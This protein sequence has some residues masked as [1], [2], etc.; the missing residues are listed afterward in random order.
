MEPFVVE[1]T[2]IGLPAVTLQPASHTSDKATHDADLIQCSDGIFGDLYY[3]E[4]S[5]DC[6]HGQCL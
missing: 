5:Q 1:A 6:S 3:L 4:H 2:H